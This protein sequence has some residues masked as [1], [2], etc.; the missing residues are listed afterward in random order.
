MRRQVTKCTFTSFA[1]KLKFGTKVSI[2]N[3]YLCL[4]LQLK[5][6]D[7]KKKKLTNRKNLLKAYQALEKKSNFKLYLYTRIVNLFSLV[8]SII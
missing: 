1:N 3:I 8:E 4:S 2:N 7:N 5:P 6:L